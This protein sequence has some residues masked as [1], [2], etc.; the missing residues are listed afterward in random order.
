MQ[1]SG[2][3]VTEPITELLPLEIEMSTPTGRNGDLA[4]DIN[5]GNLKTEERAVVSQCKYLIV[6]M[7]K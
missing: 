2:P 5:E 1:N 4:V 6:L 3:C 7:R